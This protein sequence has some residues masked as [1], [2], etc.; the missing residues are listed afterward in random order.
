M[1]IAQTHDHEN[2]RLNI[3]HNTS[4]KIAKFEKNPLHIDEVKMVKL[5]EITRD[6]LGEIIPIDTSTESDKHE[7]SETSVVRNET[8]VVYNETSV[9][10]NETSVVYNETPLKKTDNKRYCAY[11]GDLCTYRP[12]LGKYTINCI[13]CSRVR[14][15]PPLYCNICGRKSKGM[16]IN[17]LDLCCDPAV[18]NSDCYQY[19]RENP[20]N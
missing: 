19:S 8:S 2:K 10:R 6:Q 17:Y 18:T 3:L 12:T 20:Y 11:C 4:S 1:E 15:L 9:V 7:K 16:L 14:F 5:R 13:G